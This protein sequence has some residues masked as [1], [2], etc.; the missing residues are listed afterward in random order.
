ARSFFMSFDSLGLSAPIVRALVQ[1]G[2]AA[3]T[4]IQAQVIPAALEGRDVIACARTG[5]GKTA[6][7]TLPLLER[8]AAAS[9]A[10]AAAGRGPRRVRALVLSPTR[11]LAAQIE[12]SV[13][14]YG[15][16]LPLRSTT[17]YGGVSAS[18]QAAELRRGVDILVAT[19]GRLLDHLSQRT[20][21]LSGVETLVLDEADRMLDM[22]FLPAI[23]SVIQALPR[24]RQTLLFSA[25]LAPEIRKLAERMLTNPAQIDV[26]SGERTV[27]EI[28]QFMHRVDKTQKRATLAH[29]IRNGDWQQVLVFTRTKHG[30]NRLAQQL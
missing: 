1:Q 18:R 30:A 15:A 11:E 26:T 20:V 4:P 7:F 19:P 22:G 29:L 8:L 14:A 21:D 3:P 25:T 16:H 27:E 2:Y 6:A 10:G 13:R 5:T 17:V 9:T 28:E 23:R 12:Q 24:Q